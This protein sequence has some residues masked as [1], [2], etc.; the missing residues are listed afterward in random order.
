[1]FKRWSSALV[2][3]DAT[4]VVTLLASVL[5]VGQAVRE[6]RATPVR[7]KAVQAEPR[8]AASIPN[9]QASMTPRHSIP[10]H[11]SAVQV[12]TFYEDVPGKVQLCQ[13]FGECGPIT[14]VQG[15]LY[16]DCREP[17]WSDQRPIPWQMFAQ[18]EYVGPARTQH[19]LEYRLRVDDTIEFIYRLTREEDS[20][21]YRLN[22]G[23]ELA[24]E[25]LTDKNLDR[26]LIVQPDGTIT[27]RLLG[28]TRAAELTVTE[29][30]NNLLKLYGKY[31]KERAFT[32]TVTPLKVNTKLEDLRATVDSRAG[33]GGQSLITVVTPA[34]EIQLP[35]I[36]SVPAQGLTIDEL[37][38][39]VD[40]RYSQE[41]QGIEVSLVLTQRAPRHIYVVGEVGNPGRFELVGPTTVT[42]ALAL[43]GSYNIGANIRQI[44]VFRRDADWRLM[45]T[46]IDLAGALLGKRPNP[47]DEI[48]LRD[49]DIVI[50]PKSPV[51]LAD[52]FIEMV[53]TR[54]IYGVMPFQG[55]SLN[56]AKH[57]T[58]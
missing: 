23:D 51:Q 33:R 44:V 14:G 11:P 39:E 18:G 9:L 26:N 58:L 42:Q 36:G 40:E 52:D 29:L 45:A 25:S 47:A 46:R 13:A 8:I 19:V 27:L 6:R 43:A 7:Q 1:M 20:R 53:F 5:I 48:W 37:K 35:A 56:F 31:Y 22:V 55:I 30:R 2:V 4:I 15:T 54:G 34:G 24:I 3:V 32:L 41:F 28:Q 12:A 16:G 49:S 10:A 21:P 38:R 57:S 17:L 50:V